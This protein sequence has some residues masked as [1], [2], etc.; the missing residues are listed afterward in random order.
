M[1]RLK[2]KL[3]L[4]RYKKEIE[5]G[6]CEHINDLIA[7]MVLLD[8]SCISRYNLEDDMNHV[9]LEKLMHMCP[10]FLKPNREPNKYEIP[11]ME[12][13]SLLKKE[14]KKELKGISI[15][16]WAEDENAALTWI[17]MM[18]HFGMIQEGQVVDPAKFV[19]SDFMTDERLVSMFEAN[20]LSIANYKRDK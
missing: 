5:N 12:D 16:I 3:L 4:N 10:S 9:T 13:I 19:L 1:K 7:T 11:S 18:I 17:E 20:G 14:Y 15:P 8:Y 2:L 6:N